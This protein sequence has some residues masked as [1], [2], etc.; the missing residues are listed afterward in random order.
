MSDTQDSIGL[1]QRQMQ[2]RQILAMMGIA[3]W[4]QPDSPTLD[5]ADISAV[6]TA[7]PVE[8]PLTNTII[9]HDD[10]DSQMP[11]RDVVTVIDDSHQAIISPSITHQ[12]SDYRD[13]GYQNSDGQDSS[14]N[15][16][17]TNVNVTDEHPV[18]YEFDSMTSSALVTSDGQ[19]TTPN[20]EPLSRQLSN[21]ITHDSQLTVSPFDLQGGR[22]GNWVL[23]VDIQALNNDSQKLWQNIVQALSLKCETSSFPICAGMDTAELANASLAGYIFKIGRSEDISVAVLTTLPDGVTHPNFD[24]VPSL[25]AMLTDSA[26]K[27]QLWKQISH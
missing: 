1:R 19:N 21:Q 12:D 20:N 22:Y 23:M 25:E 5:M 24:S 3:Q 18:T 2:Q 17:I 7:Q 16:D 10:L 11:V 26:L 15:M 8:Q 27:R 14:S 4:V 13:N 9:E 6:A